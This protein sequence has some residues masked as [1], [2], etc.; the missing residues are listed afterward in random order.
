MKP[1]SLARS[2]AVLGDERRAVAPAAGRPDR[3]A[4]RHDEELNSRSGDD[5][6]Q[7][8]VDAEAGA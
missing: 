5:W 1:P 6:A 7:A 2:G 3:T 4:K 8:R